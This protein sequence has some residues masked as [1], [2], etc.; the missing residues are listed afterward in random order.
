MRYT[1]DNTR[2]L[3]TNDDCKHGIAQIRLELE[4]ILSVKQ[5]QHSEK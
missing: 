4:Q 5:G 1:S 2:F 3:R